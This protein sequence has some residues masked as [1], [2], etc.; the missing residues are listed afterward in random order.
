MD[1]F[2]DTV[3][4]TEVSEIVESNET[5]LENNVTIVEEKEK[6][7]N[8]L[9]IASMA[10]GILGLVAHF[11]SIFPLSAYFPFI[12]LF[13]ALGDKL[14][15]KKMTVNAK[16]GLILS[17]ITYTISVLSTLFAILAVVLYYCIILLFYFVAMLATIM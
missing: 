9:G 6:P 2:K 8:C 12:G 10:F 16:I 14:K 13:L 11:I 1:N 3:E 4:A 7:E 17:I 5:I 15:N